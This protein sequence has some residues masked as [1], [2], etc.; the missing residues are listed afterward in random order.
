MAKSTHININTSNDIIYYINN[1]RV[2]N[3]GSIVFSGSL[4]VDRNISLM[5]FIV[6][7]NFL[8]GVD[9]D[10]SFNF[11]YPATLVYKEY[12]LV[13]N[14]KLNLSSYKNHFRT[15]INRISN[16]IKLIC[17]DDIE[18]NS[19]SIY[20]LV[21]NGHKSANNFRAVPIIR[22]TNTKEYIWKQNYYGN[23]LYTS[24]IEFTKKGDVINIKFPSKETRHLTIYV[25][26]YNA[27]I[28][29]FI[30]IDSI[31]LNEIC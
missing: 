23:C 16:S 12:S 26:F 29:N 2:F 19:N 20:E 1:G 27:I 13:D 3:V 14:N 21:I 15:P 24:N 5:T 11:K 8:H 30:V 4:L 7:T 31:E 25:L 17:S 6:L 10:T 18:I 22:D 9:N 28:Q